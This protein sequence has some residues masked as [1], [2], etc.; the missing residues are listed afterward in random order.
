MYI[1]IFYKELFSFPQTST[2]KISI[3]KTF[4][5]SVRAFKCLISLMVII[6]ELTIQIKQED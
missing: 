3:T 4:S 5:D 6:E 1:H 2:Y